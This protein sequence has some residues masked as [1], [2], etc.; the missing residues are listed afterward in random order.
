MSVLRRAWRAASGLRDQIDL[1]AVRDAVRAA[2]RDD[3]ADDDGRPGRADRDGQRRPPL[4]DRALVARARALGAPDPFAL[5][6]EDEAAVALGAPAGPP[7]LTHGDD[8]IGVIH[9]AASGAGGALSVSAFHATDDGASFDAS[10]HWHDFLAPIVADEAQAVPGV[11]R[12]ALR[13]TG[14][15]YVLGDDHLLYLTLT[16]PDGAS[17]DAPLGA[18]AR[19]VLGRVERRR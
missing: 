10:A 7:V 14:G 18:L 19:A 15:L 9:A 17:P 3:D 11:G 16:R 6:G 8:T 13:T 2:D 4:D 5:V 1:D 12:A